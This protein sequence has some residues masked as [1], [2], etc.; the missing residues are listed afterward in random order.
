MQSASGY[1]AKMFDTLFRSG[2]N[3]EMITTSEIRITCIV[4]SDQ[5]TRAVQALHSAFQ[6][7]V[8]DEQ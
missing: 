2:I 1:A 3:I 6:V 4:A 8:P 7:E 5:V